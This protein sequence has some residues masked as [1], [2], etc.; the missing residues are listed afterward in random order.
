MFCSNCGAE[1]RS[2]N[3]YCK[4][5][6]EWLPD[7]KSSRAKWG[8]ETPAQH[9]TVML[10][11]NG[12]SALAALFSAIIL[13]A[14]HLGGESGMPWPVALTAALCISISAWQISAFL[15][16]LKL[17][18]RLQRGRGE[19]ESQAVL[20]ERRGQPSLN[21]GDTSQFVNSRSI[22]ENTTELL[23]PVPERT[24]DRKR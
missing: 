11:L 15:I 22:T 13:Y 2:V 7:L 8:G 4:R 18:R 20:D 6:G 3:A 23:T 9:V 12:F 10:F 16:G 14:T 21:A 5:C 19:I 1:S 24:S 17:R